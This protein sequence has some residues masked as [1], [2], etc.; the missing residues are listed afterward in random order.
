MI[1]CE[2]PLKG[3]HCFRGHTADFTHAWVWFTLLVP[4]SITQYWENSIKVMWHLRELSV[5]SGKN[6]NRITLQDY[7]SVFIFF[8]G[9]CYKKNH[10]NGFW[11]MDI[12]QAR[13]RQ[14]K[15][16]S[17]CIMGNVRCKDYSASDTILNPLS[18]SIK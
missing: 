18:I 11:K 16:L 4:R 10:A 7:L 8:T 6:K 14:S 15:M 17:I 12:Y 13:R 3:V 1:K 5:K 2:R 9:G